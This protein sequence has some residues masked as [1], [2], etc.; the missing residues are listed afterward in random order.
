MQYAKVKPARSED[1]SRPVNYGLAG[2]RA[3]PGPTR[4]YLPV[5]AAVVE[6]VLTSRQR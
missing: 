5:T 3:T 6:G 2:T 4:L 1:G